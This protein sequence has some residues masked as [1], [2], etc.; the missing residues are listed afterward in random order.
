LN[1]NLKKQAKRQTNGK[2][3]IKKDKLDTPKRAAHSLTTW[4]L[5]FLVASELANLKEKIERRESGRLGPDLPAPGS[6]TLG[7]DKI[8]QLTVE[9][10][11]LRRRVTEVQDEA[12]ELRRA[13]QEL[14]TRIRGVENER[15]V[16][17]KQSSQVLG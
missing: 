17:V 14:E 4:F 3:S 7:A 9:M 2:V 10:R 5:F 1:A 11:S 6:A 16:A 8:S 13:K 15:D 12:D